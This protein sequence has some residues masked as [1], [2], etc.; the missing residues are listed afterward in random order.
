MTGDGMRLVVVIGNP[1]P[2]SRTRA[3]ATRTAD[4][5]RAALAAGDRPVSDHAVIDLV[6]LAPHLLDA[7]ANGSVVDAAL[8]TVRR[9]RLLV[10]ASPTFK[11]AYSGLLKLFLDLL[12]R[13]GLTGAVAVPLMTAGMAAHRGA[14]ET[15]LR[16]VLVELGARVPTAGITVLESEFS[17]VDEVFDSWWAGHGA[18]LGA[19]LGVTAA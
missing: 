4:R 19:V 10:V 1:K 9:A 5:L 3:V 16:P 17:D 6:E 8:G 18:V 12:P 15:T 13:R 2:H 7:D 11:G 14:V